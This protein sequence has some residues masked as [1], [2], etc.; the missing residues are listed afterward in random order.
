MKAKDDERNIHERVLRRRW[1]LGSR[2][3]GKPTGGIPRRPLMPRVAFLERCA[4]VT[5][6]SS[7]R[8]DSTGL[9]RKVRPR[10]LH[11]YSDG[12]K[13][14]TVSLL[15]R[16]HDQKKQTRGR[17]GRHRIFRNREPRST[18]LPLPPRPGPLVRSTPQ[19]ATQHRLMQCLVPRPVSPRFEGEE[20]EFGLP[21]RS[22]VRRPGRVWSR[23]TPRPPPSSP[24]SRLAAPP[25]GCP[26]GFVRAPQR[27]DPRTSRSVLCTHA[28]AVGAQRC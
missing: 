21:A 9:G 26:P 27:G 14:N 5:L 16:C 7:A 24:G 15:T 12:R 17:S 25:V 6:A 3:L 28:P 19:L 4:W 1:R 22:L 10:V 11:P 2:C 18:A 23:K 20:D 8:L 13:R